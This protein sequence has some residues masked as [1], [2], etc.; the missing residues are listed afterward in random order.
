MGPMSRKARV[1]SLSKSLKH[2]ISPIVEVVV[3]LVGYLNTGKDSTLAGE[4]ASSDFMERN[5]WVISKHLA[6]SYT[7]K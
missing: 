7:E 2:G 1:F 5:S 6:L 3:Q 4:E